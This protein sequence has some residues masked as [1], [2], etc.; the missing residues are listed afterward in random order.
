MNRIHFD[1][2][3]TI[4]INTLFIAMN[5]HLWITWNRTKFKALNDLT[6]IDEG[7]E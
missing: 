5:L 6:M 2:A 3:S 1:K 4:I 7:I